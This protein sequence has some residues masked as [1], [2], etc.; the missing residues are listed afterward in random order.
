MPGVFVALDAWRFF[1]GEG[2]ELEP[3]GSGA[4]RVECERRAAPP[5]GAVEVPGC[6]VSR[7]VLVDADEV[8]AF[9]EKGELP[10]GLDEV[11]DVLGQGLDLLLEFFDS[12]G[13]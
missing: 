11:I 8:G 7:S 6:A 10:D 2:E 5:A 12:V 1:G 4:R 13:E 3:W 9:V